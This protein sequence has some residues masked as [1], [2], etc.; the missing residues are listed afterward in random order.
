[1]VESIVFVNGNR[2]NRMV[3]HRYQ[4]MCAR[5]I[6]SCGH[7]H[8]RLERRTSRYPRH[9]TM[10]AKNKVHPPLGIIPAW[11]QILRGFTHRYC[12]VVYKNCDMK[13]R[14]LLLFHYVTISINNPVDLFL[15]PL[16]LQNEAPDGGKPRNENAYSLLVS[17]VFEILPRS[18]RFRQRCRSLDNRAVRKSRNDIPDGGGVKRV[19]LE[20]GIGSSKHRE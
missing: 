14:S 20:L 7:F 8:V 13:G 9:P 10:S 2:N 11:R 16:Q 18:D 4:G 6:P 15:L 17:L 5:K 1:M 12:L 19:L 3:V